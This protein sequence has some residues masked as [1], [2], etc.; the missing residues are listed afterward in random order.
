MT[1]TEDDSTESP[2]RSMTSIVKSSKVNDIKGW[3]SCRCSCWGGRSITATNTPHSCSRLLLVPLVVVAWCAL[4]PSQ[5]N[6]LCRSLTDS[7]AYRGS[8]C[9]MDQQS[10]LLYVHYAM[11]CSL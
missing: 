10:G 3:D 11:L 6:Q 5:V 8:A 7:A 4:C 2:V 1:S 9:H